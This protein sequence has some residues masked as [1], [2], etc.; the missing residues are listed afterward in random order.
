MCGDGNDTYSLEITSAEICG[1]PCKI[2][3]GKVRMTLK[4]DVLYVVKYTTNRT[5][6][7]SSEVIMNAY[8]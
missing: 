3:N 5:S 2:E 8:R 7:F 4:K 6:M 1:V